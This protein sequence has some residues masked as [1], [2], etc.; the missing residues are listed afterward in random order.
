MSL[1]LRLRFLLRKD[2]PFA[3]ASAENSG[4]DMGVG[5]LGEFRLGECRLCAAIFDATRFSVSV[6]HDCLP[7]GDKMPQF[8]QLSVLACRD[9]SPRRGL[10][11]R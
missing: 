8:A 7:E 10:A 4:R 9:E 5:G 3:A 1:T 2:T 11:A 6:A